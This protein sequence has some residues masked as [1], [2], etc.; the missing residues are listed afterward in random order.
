MQQ[1]NRPATL[2]GAQSGL[3]DLFTLKEP[4]TSSMSDYS[5]KHYTVCVKDPFDFVC[6]SLMLFFQ[7]SGHI[8]NAR[9]NNDSLPAGTLLLSVTEHQSK[10]LYFRRISIGYSLDNFISNTSDCFIQKKPEFTIIHIIQN[11][12]TSQDLF[13]WLLKQGIDYANSYHRPKLEGLF[14]NFASSIVKDLKDNFTPVEI[15]P[16][17]DPPISPTS[18]PNEIK[19]SL[20]TIFDVFYNWAMPTTGYRELQIDEGLI[21]LHRPSIFR[22]SSNCLI[23]QLGTYLSPN[24]LPHDIGFTICFDGL[25]LGASTKIRASCR[26]PVFLTNYFKSILE[27]L[28]SDYPET[29]TAIRSYIDANPTAQPP[30]VKPDGDVV[31][32]LPTKPDDP[33]LIEA[34]RNE[35]Y[36][37]IIAYTNSGKSPT[38]IEE[39]MSLS[40]NQANTDLSRIRKN[41]KLSPFVLPANRDD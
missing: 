21:C 18:E 40:P 22:N 26:Y 20:N 29:R 33:R 35:K 32:A 15:D 17:I 38:Q 6:Q 13:E 25:E 9:L 12:K 5:E 27:E 24:S 2:D 30:P 14:S 34:T 10:S 19:F 4:K 3:T 16:R 23:T 31:L 28:S 41:A 8:I 7:K 39:L 11:G 1:K 36:R 37:K